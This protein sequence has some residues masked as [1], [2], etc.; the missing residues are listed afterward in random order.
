LNDWFTAT[1]THRNFWPQGGQNPN[2]NQQQLSPTWLRA[3]ALNNASPGLEELVVT[4][5][6]QSASS[7]YVNASFST[8]SSR[9]DL[10][11][12]R[13]ITNDPELALR[14][15]IDNVVGY[16]FQF[17][18]HKTGTL[19]DDSRYRGEDIGAFLFDPDNMDQLLYQHSIV[20]GYLLG[21]PNIRPALGLEASPGVFSGCMVCNPGGSIVALVIAVSPNTNFR[22]ILGRGR[23]YNRFSRAISVPVYVTANGQDVVRFTGQDGRAR[24]VR[25]R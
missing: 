8:A 25:P 18:K 23:A 2:P 14:T 20:G 13:R 3:G 19:L 7:G 16:R 10:A 1:T 17:N 4:A 5:S 22:Q 9:I 21:D 6:R 15:Q 12:P 11:I 24:L